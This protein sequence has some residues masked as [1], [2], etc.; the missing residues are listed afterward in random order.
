MSTEIIEVK[1][2]LE[3]SLDDNIFINWA[4]RS[5]NTSNNNTIISETNK[6]SHYWNKKFPFR[7]KHIDKEI[8][9]DMDILND[10]IKKEL[11]DSLNKEDSISFTV[12]WKYCQFIRWVEKTCFYHNDLTKT[13]ICDSP[14]YSGDNSE[15]ERVLIIQSSD[16]II[17]LSLKKTRNEQSKGSILDLND[18]E[19]ISLYFK[20]INIDIKRKYGKML[21]NKF[22]VIDG[23]TSIRDNSDEYLIRT[24]NKI[25]KDSIINH[26]LSIM[27]FIQNKLYLDDFAIKE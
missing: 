18:S 22:T 21:N 2:N 23:Q 9:T 8:V 11:I 15:D 3:E 19:Y 10:S 6:V 13:I 25:V 12:L 14:M 27:N 5:Y 26:F 17:K 4:I 16:V 24:V 7:H 1:N 20:V